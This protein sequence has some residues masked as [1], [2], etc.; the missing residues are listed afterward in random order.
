MNKIH[1]LHT[2]G[3]S[4]I[5]FAL[6]LP[7]FLFVTMGIFDLGRTI[8]YYST[9]YNAAREGARYGAVNYC[10]SDGIKEKSSFATAGLTD[11]IEVADP[12]IDFDA[13]G[14]PEYVVTTVQYR[15]QA[16][17]PMIGVLLGGDGSITLTSQSMKHIEQITDC[18]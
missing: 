3:Q 15:F 4:L 14:I 8:Y 9:I 11:G 17:T 2:K 7:L 6:I 10:D 5:E 18:H 12:V 1:R 16:V 13:E